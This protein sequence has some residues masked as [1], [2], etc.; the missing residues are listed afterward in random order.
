MSETSTLGTSVGR[1]K[2]F[3]NKA[4]YGFITLASKEQPE[5]DIFVHHSSIN[6]GNE[7]YKY[8]VQGEYVEFKLENTTGGSHAYQATFVSGINGGKLMCE[9]RR[10]S[11]LVRNNYKEGE[12]NVVENQEVKKPTTNSRNFDRPRVRG[13]GPRDSNEWKIVGSSTNNDGV[14]PR[15]NKSTN[16]NQTIS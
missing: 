1:V 6:V 8:L 9:T 11:K 5:T 2:W 3:N 7:Q 14:R 13:G 15:H 4:G 16:N 12:E 10:Q